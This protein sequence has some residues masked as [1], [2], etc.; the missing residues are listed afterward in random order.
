MFSE[1]ELASIVV[2]IC[3]NIHY[4]YGP[5]LFESIYED[6]FCHELKKTKIPFT[7]Q[8]SIPVIHDNILLENSFRADVIVE[9]KLLIEFKSIEMLLPIHFKQLRTYLIITNLSL[10]LLI[11]F[12]VLRIKDGINRVVNKL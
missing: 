8:Q 5:G 10:G 2:D 3:Y 6:I 9:N 7:R 11:N 4:K 1:N 12:N